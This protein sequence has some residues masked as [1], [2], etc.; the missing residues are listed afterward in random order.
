MTQKK[1]YRN[2][3]AND[4]VKEKVIR[5][6]LACANKEIAYKSDGTTIP[7]ADCLVFGV[8][9]IGGLWRVQEKFPYTINNIRG[10]D[11]VLFEKLPHT[12]KT[13]FTFY[14]AVMV[15]E[16]CYGRHLIKEPYIV[17]KYTTKDGD[18]WG[19]GKTIEQARAFLGVKLYDEYKDL[20]HKYA[21]KTSQE[22]QKK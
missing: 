3:L 15:G 5:Y 18:F 13:L 10:V 1:Q 7:L 21:G 22:N 9:F 11:F 6:H 20:I 17:A 14:N 12:E 4:G 2:S 16:N 8:E 19:Y